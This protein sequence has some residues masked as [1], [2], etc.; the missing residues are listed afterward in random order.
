[1]S[2]PSRGQAIVAVLLAFVGFAA[3][4]QVQSNERDDDYTGLRQADLIRVFDG[5]SA[6]TERARSEI[7]R[8]SETRDDLRSSSSR[9]QAALDKAREDA[10]VYGILAGTLPATGP[11]VRITITDE[12]GTV[13]YSTLL[14]ALQELRAA[15]AEA[16]E[17]ND[18]VRVIAQTSIEQTTL[19]IE[20]DGELIEA[21]YVIDVIGE[22]TTLA[23]SL[24]F[25]SGPTERV[26]EEGGSV[27]FEEPDEVLI[28]SVVK[29]RP[30]DFA[31]PRPEQ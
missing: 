2:R 31:E 18:R 30:G 13:K 17:V 15:G 14:D 20:F 16:I 12:A 9:R 28:E 21:P 7:A 6:S 8:L 22:P 11:G 23:G 24:D 19:G 3:M 27:Q 4:T 26:G 10:A 1:M 25:P 5:L 29:E